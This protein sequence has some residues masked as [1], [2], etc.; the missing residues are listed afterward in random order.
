MNVASPAPSG[1]M[2]NETPMAT[3]SRGS[4]PPNQ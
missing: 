1:S 4:Q 2:A 3:P